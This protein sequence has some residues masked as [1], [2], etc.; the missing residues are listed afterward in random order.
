MSLV[1]TWSFSRLMKF[2]QCPYALYLSA[3]KKLPTPEQDPTKGAG[4]GNIVHDNAE[5]WVKGETEDL[6]PV[7]TKHFAGEFRVLKEDYER[8]CCILEEDWG[9]N[10]DWGPTTWE[11][12]D[13]WC[14]M[15]LDNFRTEA[16]LNTGVDYAQVIDYKTGRKFGN[17]V[18]HIQQAQVYMIGAFMK[19][20]QLNHVKVEFWY[21]DQ[22][23][24]LQK[25]YSRD[26]LNQYLNK[27][28]QRA[29]RL[30]ECDNFEAK[31][32]K[33]HCRWCDYGVANGTGACEFAVPD[34]K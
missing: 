13:I 27:F 32:S 8:G 11:A 25:L 29:L 7:I 24:K 9:F 17:E 21:F 19:F 22:N 28:T 15:K 5:Q 33:M 34:E 3:Y 30:T 26:N 1:P 14:K 20:P 18:K 16:P 6:S 2:E 23:S 12:D 10:K 31:P 4:R